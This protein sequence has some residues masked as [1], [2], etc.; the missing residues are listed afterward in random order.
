MCTEGINV[1]F[2]KCYSFF[3]VVCTALRTQ[4]GLL[5]LWNNDTILHGGL[6]GLTFFS[7]EHHFQLLPTLFPGGRGTLYQCQRPLEID[8]KGVECLPLIGL[9]WG[10]EGEFGTSQWGCGLWM[11]W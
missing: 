2:Q 10:V 5:I 6:Q 3:I 1:F 8:G 7:L 11:S 9:I 4:R